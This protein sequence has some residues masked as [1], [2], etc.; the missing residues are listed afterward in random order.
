MSAAQ[1]TEAH[2]AITES[3]CELLDSEE[4]VGPSPAERAAQLIANSEAK[5]VAGVNASLDAAI[6]RAWGISAERDQL[7]AELARLDTE[8]PWLK[9]ANAT[10]ADLRAEVER[11]R[12]CC[13]QTS[14]LC[15]K[16]ITEDD[17]T[18]L[19]PNSARIANALTRLKARAERAEREV[20]EQC[21]LNGKG[22]ER[23][24]DLLGNLQRA[25]REI[26]QKR[27]L[28]TVAIKSAGDQAARAERAETKVS[29][30]AERIRYLEG[31]TNHAT[32]TPLSLAIARAERAEAELANIRALAN[33][34]NK[35]DHA[36]DT[37]HQLVAALDQ[38]LEIAQAELAATKSTLD[39]EVNCAEKAEHEVVRQYARAERAQAELATER[40]KVKTLRSACESICEEWGKNHDAPFCAGSEM[41]KLASKALEKLED[42]P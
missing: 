16:F 25:E 4:M 29:N 8:K 7:R 28:L 40:A 12:E 27:N 37:T 20:E 38:A 21:L 1:V 42:A 31:A 10:V 6:I 36:A 33:R 35:R 17:G 32:G 11:L 2:R 24:A 22:A 18:D 19:I 41:E 13:D 5:A 26:E 23:E 34:R 3:V 15:G 30:Q 9:E 14:A 39:E